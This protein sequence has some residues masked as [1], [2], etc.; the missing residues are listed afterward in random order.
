MSEKRIRE[1]EKLITH[2][3]SLYYQGHAEI[4]DEA[5]DALE[6]ELKKIDPKNTVLEL[7]GSPID[8]SSEKV[9]HQKKM[10]SLEKTYLE[11]D[12]AKFLEQGKLVSVFKIDGSSCSLIYEKGRL[13][14]A[15]TRGDGSQG[16]N[17]TRKV[18]YISDI[19]KKL[20]RAID[21][22]IRG[23]I[24][25]RAHA[26]HAISTE[27]ERQK[28][29]RPT[30]QRNIVAG[31]LGR[32]EHITFSKHLSFQA[33]DTIGVKYQA[34]S[35]KLKDLSSLGFEVPEWQLHSNA[36]SIKKRIDEAK[37]F[38]T[39]GDYLIDGLVFILDDQKLHEELGETSHHP[40][41]KLAFKFQGESK[42]T[43]INSITWQVSRNGRLTPVAEVEPTELSGALI[44]RVTL[45]NMGVV[46]D[47]SLKSGDQIEIVR[48]GEVIPKF[49]S[50]KMS[51][52]G[53]PSLP[54]NCPS[55]EAKLL[56]E[57]IWLLCTNDE[58]PGKRL[59]SIL[60]WIRQANIEDLSEKRLQEMINRDFVKDIPDL[61]RITVMDL[62]TFDKVKEKLAQKLFDNIQKTKRIDLAV[63][64]SALGVEGV[65][66]TKAEKIVAH[67]H[68]SL[69]KLM[70]L[71]VVTLSSI[72]GFAEKSATDI[73]RSI[74]EKKKLIKE[75]IKLEFEIIVPEVIDGGVL[76][77]KKICITGTLSA[78]RSE[79]EKQIKKNG[80]IVVGSV[81]K[82]T[83]YLLT[84][85]TDPS[86]SKYKKALEIGTPVLSEAAFF[87]LIEG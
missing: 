22:E 86:S 52:P 77:G 12:L 30:S 80:G 39:E 18:A 43:T 67:G 75:L 26:F 73:V 20:T 61:Y 44:S 11:E 50:V 79:I 84:N 25:C 5:Y 71:D 41:Y 15:K 8:S 21:I 3:K 9:A 64:M 46:K 81:S 28:L 47:F 62:L 72:D 65:S 6:A 83:D 2:H 68:N 63:F 29:E 34:E 78:P 40:R 66:T 45:H 10:L 37:S 69:E 51:K 85:D 53:K 36:N 48:S 32:K 16:E 60:H 42:V 14:M 1:L 56:Q 70:A 87:K 35:E 58:C 13:V 33:F 57:D 76:E 23:E 31:L 38:M 74:Q 49:L 54:E 82:N 24:F 7:I 59:E 19:P 4:S 27:M 17:I 55:C